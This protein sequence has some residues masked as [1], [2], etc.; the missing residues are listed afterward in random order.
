[1][2]LHLQRRGAGEAVPPDSAP[3][4]ARGRERAGASFDVRTLAVLLAGGEDA[5]TLRERVTAA[6]ARC[7]R[8]EAASGKV[9]VL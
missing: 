2:S 1:V 7:A 4:G 3:A 9:P 8:V 6:V 5:Y